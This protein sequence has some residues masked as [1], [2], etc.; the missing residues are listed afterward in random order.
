MCVCVCVEEKTVR[1]LL[2]N[3]CNVQSGLIKC[4][5]WILTFVRGRMSVMPFSFN[6]KS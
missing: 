2:F 6:S 1:K 4:T 3:V 5:W